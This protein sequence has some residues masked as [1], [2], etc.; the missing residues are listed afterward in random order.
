[1]STVYTL[2]RALSF[3]LLAPLQ[4][5]YGLWINQF[6]TPW[7]FLILLLSGYIFAILSSPYDTPYE[8]AMLSLYCMALFFIGLVLIMKIVKTFVK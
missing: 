4:F 1:M 5:C 2:G 7:L 6:S 3:S 8:I